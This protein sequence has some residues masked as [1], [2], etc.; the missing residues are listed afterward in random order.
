MQCL[1]QQVSRV[2]CLC[3]STNKQWFYSSV[4]NKKPKVINRTAAWPCPQQPIALQKLWITVLWVR[5][6][7]VFN[8][9]DFVPPWWLWGSVSIIKCIWLSQWPWSS[10]G[11]LVV[12]MVLWA[13]QNFIRDAD[14][15]QYLWDCSSAGHGSG[16]NLKIKLNHHS[17]C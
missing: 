10:M 14:M 3:Q 15:T 8:Y 12:T 7:T 11:G 9:K 13:T 4:S 16:V 1:M 2:L 5:W 6:M 17:T